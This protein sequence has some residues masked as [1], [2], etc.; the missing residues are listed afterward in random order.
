[1]RM[2]GVLE[3]L[4]T[5]VSVVV[6][7]VDDDVFDLGGI[8]TDFFQVFADLLLNRV[9]VSG[10][11]EDDSIRGGHRPYGLIVQVAVSNIVEIVEDLYWIGTPSP[12]FLASRWTRH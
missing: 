6:S 9:V 11:D 5:E 10:I 2:V 12:R 7:M 1:M 8:E 3:I 4:H